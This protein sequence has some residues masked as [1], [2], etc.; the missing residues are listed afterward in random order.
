MYCKWKVLKETKIELKKIVK[1]DTISILSEFSP[2]CISHNSSVTCSEKGSQDHM[3]NPGDRPDQAARSHAVTATWG[4]K[5]SCIQPGTSPY[6]LL[7]P[8]VLQARRLRPRQYERSVQG[9]L[10]FRG[11]SSEACPFL[12]LLCFFFFFKIF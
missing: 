8:T 11:A 12:L 5:R 9:D 10:F 6:T 7:P 4:L 3:L 1:F 2:Q